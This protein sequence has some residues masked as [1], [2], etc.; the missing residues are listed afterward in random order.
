MKM[1]L[2]IVNMKSPTTNYIKLGKRERKKEIIWEKIIV[3]QTSDVSL[4]YCYIN[5][6]VN[7]CLKQYSPWPDIDC[8]INEMST[9]QNMHA[10]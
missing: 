5:F 9:K 10:K 2:N 4:F 7:T 3:C 6:I 8:K 1:M